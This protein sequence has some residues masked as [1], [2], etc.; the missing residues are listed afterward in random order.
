M[1][2]LTLSICKGVSIRRTANRLTWRRSRPHGGAPPHPPQEH[3]TIYHIQCRHNQLICLLPSS[4][5]AARA[6]TG[7][8]AL[9]AKRRIRPVRLDLRYIG[10]ETVHQNTHL[11]ALDTPPR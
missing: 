2:S 10:A 11:E 5:S 7:H 9:E 6:L 4:Q 3:M 8:S 1:L